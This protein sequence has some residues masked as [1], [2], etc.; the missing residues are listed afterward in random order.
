MLIQ[1]SFSIFDY[2]ALRIQIII[3]ICLGCPEPRP[4]HYAL[5]D[6]GGEDDDDVERTAPKKC[7]LPILLLRLKLVFKVSL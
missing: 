3:K 4:R 7:N 1:C 6:K 2:L 5:K